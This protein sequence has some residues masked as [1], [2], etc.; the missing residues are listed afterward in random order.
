MKV[1][2][3]ELLDVSLGNVCYGPVGLDVHGT[4]A[5]DLETN[6]AVNY[7]VDGVFYSKTAIASIDLSSCVSAR[8]ADEAVEIPAGTTG[9]IYCLMDAAGA[10]TTI[11]VNDGVAWDP[12]HDHGDKVVFGRAVVENTAGTAFVVGTTLLSSVTAS[13]EDLARFM[14]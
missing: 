4:N 9:R 6:N 10:V 8:E 11:L 1:F 14:G 2:P 13:Y 12:T 7:T 5:A 3:S